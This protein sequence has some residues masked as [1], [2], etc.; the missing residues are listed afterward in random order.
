LRVPVHASD[1]MEL[2]PEIL[3]MKTEC[4]RE[5]L[6]LQLVAATMRFFLA[7]CIKLW[8]VSPFVTS[9]I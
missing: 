7:R 1:V 3:S 9:S 6:S 2:T 4:E 5:D 8:I